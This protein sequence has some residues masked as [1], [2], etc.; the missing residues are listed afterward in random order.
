MKLHRFIRDFNFAESRLKIFDK[1]I[2]DQIKNVLRLGAGEKIILS[3]GNLNEALA[4]INNFKKDYLEV[5]ILEVGKNENEPKVRAVLYCSILKRENFEL[6]A[7]KAVEV[8]IAE[9][10]PIVAKRTVK[11]NLKEERLKKIIR[12]AA[13][14]SGRGRVPVLQ[15][16]IDFAEAVEEAE[17]NNVNLFFDVSG[18]NIKNFF[19]SHFRGNDRETVGVFIGPEGGWDEEEIKMARNKNFKIVSLGRLTLRAETA[20]AVASYVVASN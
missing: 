5:E 11:L 12:E 9:I 13:E 20:A 15:P 4:Q 6:A 19:D 14:Q 2:L 17:K 3:D 18:K 8:G 10:V 16:V 1:E 7:Q